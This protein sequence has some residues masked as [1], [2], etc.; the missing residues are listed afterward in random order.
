MSI[1]INFVSAGVL[2]EGIF[3]PVSI[4]K[5]TKVNARV[6]FWEFMMRMDEG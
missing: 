5:F 4:L 3:S 2:F 6:L 1:F